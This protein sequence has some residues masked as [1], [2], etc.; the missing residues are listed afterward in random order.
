MELPPFLGVVVRTTPRSRRLP[1]GF[2][3]YDRSEPTAQRFPYVAALRDS[4]RWFWVGLGWVGLELGLGLGWVLVGA[5]LGWSWGWDWVRVW[6]VLVRRVLRAV[7]EGR[8]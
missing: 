6:L 8:M 7:E 2:P 4:G 1:V 5:G 3:I